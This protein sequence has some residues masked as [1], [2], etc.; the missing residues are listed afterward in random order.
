MAEL[1]ALNSEKDHQLRAF[2]LQ[3]VEVEAAHN[4]K[5]KSIQ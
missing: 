4:E 5:L 3:S 1:K 2:E